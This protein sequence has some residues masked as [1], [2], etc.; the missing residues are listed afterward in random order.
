MASQMQKEFEK[1]FYNL[2]KDIEIPETRREDWT[3]LTKN[4]N[5]I[6]KNCDNAQQIIDI[7]FIINYL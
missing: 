1:K 3:W 5:K 2:T 7:L 6:T 4:C